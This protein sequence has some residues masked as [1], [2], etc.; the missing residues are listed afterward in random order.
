MK[1]FFEMNIP[2]EQMRMDPHLG[3]HEVKTA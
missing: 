1:N 2:A 3:I